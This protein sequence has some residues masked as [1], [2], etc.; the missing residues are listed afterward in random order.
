[1]AGDRWWLVHHDEKRAEDFLSALTPG[2]GLLDTSYLPGGWIYR[3]TGSADHELVPSAFRGDAR[4]VNRALR[5]E[6]GPARTVGGQIQLELGTLLTFIEAAD[7][8]GHAIPEDSHALRHEL[9]ILQQQLADVESGTS[10]ERVQVWPHPRFFAALGLAQHYGI[11]T[12]LL[13]WTLN[14][15]VAI[16]FAADSALRLAGS[17]GMLCV[18]AFLRDSFEF[19]RRMSSDKSVLNRRLPLKLALTPAAYNPNLKAQH[20]V[21]LVYQHFNVA[22]KHPFTARTYDE[23]LVENLHLFRNVRAPFLFQFRLPVSESG[24][25][26]RLLATQGVDGASIFPSLEGAAK[27][28]KDQFHWPAE[29]PDVRPDRYKKKLREYLAPYTNKDDDS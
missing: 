7:R 9:M 4:F 11:S 25:L 14:P 1:M 28:V 24:H 23:L 20:G 5:K 2:R 13:D 18:W 15:F 21:F 26:L 27:V 6:H 17:S 19:E 22:A 12:R 10:S 29:A 8:Q 16:Y 3:G